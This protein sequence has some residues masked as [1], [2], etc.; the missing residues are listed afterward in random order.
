MSGLKTGETEDAMENRTEFY[1]SD[2]NDW[3]RFLEAHFRTSREIWL[4][5]PMK[6][7]GE[8]CLPYNDAV[9]E[10]LCFGWIDSTVRHTDLLHRAQRF[11]PRKK[12]GP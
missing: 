12:G 6:G 3:R 8:A 1:T 10:A 11:T 9:E 5:Y 2:R 4:L 7:S